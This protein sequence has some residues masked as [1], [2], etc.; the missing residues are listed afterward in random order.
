MPCTLKALK[1]QDVEQCCHNYSTICK[2]SLI[3]QSLTIQA[4]ANIPKLQ[5]ST[6]SLSASIDAISVFQIQ[7]LYGL[8]IDGSERIVAA[9]ICPSNVL[10]RVNAIQQYSVVNLT[11]DT[12]DNVDVYPLRWLE[13]APFP[14]GLELI[15]NSSSNLKMNS[16]QCIVMAQAQVIANTSSVATKNVTLSVQMRPAPLGIELSRAYFDVDENQLVEIPVTLAASNGSRRLVLEYP[17]LLVANISWQNRT[18]AMSIAAQ[19][20]NYTV[21]VGPDTIVGMFRIK[22]MPYMTG[23]I[24]LHLST[25]PSTL[26]LSSQA[27]RTKYSVMVHV[28][29][30]PTLPVFHVYPRLSLVNTSSLSSRRLRTATLYLDLQVVDPQDQIHVDVTAPSGSI[31]ALWL[32]NHYTLEETPLTE[33][34]NA[35]SVLYRFP[36]ATTST[37]N[38]T[39]TTIEM[40]VEVTAG[41]AGRFM[42]RYKIVTFGLQWSKIW[43][44]HDTLV[45]GHW[46]F[47]HDTQWQGKDSY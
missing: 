34:K 26:E 18:T 38:H 10:R 23:D 25:M 44:Y 35:L 13:N 1:I 19:D 17:P 27:E 39:D 12:Y 11:R 32:V 37:M 42:V 46:R 8:A 40:K 6:T 22:L 47:Q 29:P 21:L 7:E 24:L 20:G 5:L 30:L 36:H 9:L 15:W 3:N 16:F 43:M 28:H 45:D 14:I 31:Q 33:E 2:A 41:F 4:V